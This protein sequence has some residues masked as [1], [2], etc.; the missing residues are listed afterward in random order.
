MNNY[1][2]KKQAR[3]EKLNDR[4]IAAANKS[5]S[6][7]KSSNCI[8]EGI[9]VGQPIL[10]GHHSEKGHRRA[11]EKSNNYMR[12]GIEANKKSEELAD[13]AEAAENNTAISSDDPEAIALLREKIKKLTKKQEIMKKAN[14]ALKKK[15]DT[16]LAMLGFSE[17]SITAL[18]TPDYAGRIGFPAYELTN[19]N[20]N[21]SRLKKRLAGLEKHVGDKTTEKEINGIKIVENV[22]DNRCQLFFPDK[23]NDEIRA[24]LNKNGFHFSRY[25]GRCWQR[26]RSGHATSLAEY[27]CR[28]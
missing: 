19:N 4:A 11:I 14:K 15:D 23:P 28:M 12:K 26:Q 7:F 5:K 3:I 13:R 22:E 8:I 18:K 24:Y 21:I 25:Y 1:Q 9:P 16:A 2:E 10:V 6:Y 20:A 27:A 17:K